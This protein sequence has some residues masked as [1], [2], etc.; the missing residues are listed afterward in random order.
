[1]ERRGGGVT[2]RAGHSYTSR[3]EVQWVHRGV[4]IEIRKLSPPLGL[5]PQPELT[6]VPRVT[7]RSTKP[8]TF[9]HHYG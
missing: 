4:H 2:Q 7:T 6:P 8:Y 5:G 3:L 1:M 9:A